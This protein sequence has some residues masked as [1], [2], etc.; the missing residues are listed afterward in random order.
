MKF[1]QQAWF[2]DYLDLVTNESD[3]EVDIAATRNALLSEPPISRETSD[4]FWSHVQDEADAEILLHEILERGP[5]SPPTSGNELPSIQKSRE[6]LEVFLNLPRDQQL[7]QL[8]RM[9]TLRPILDEYYSE[10]DRMKF[11]EQHGQTLLDGVEVEHLVNDPDGH[12]TLQD[13]GDDELTKKVDADTKFSIKKIP[14]GTDEYGMGRNEKARMLYRAWN[15]QKAG[16]AR[17]AELRFKQGKMP[18]KEEE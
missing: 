1:S 5:P 11:M 9:G 16:R 4:S 18:L 14:F 7:R 15:M 8:V 17:Y 10:A 6:A 13:I 12:I 3:G 2:S